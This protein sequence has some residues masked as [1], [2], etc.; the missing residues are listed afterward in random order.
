M[1]NYVSLNLFFIFYFLSESNL[2]SLDLWY[3]RKKNVS[4]R[5]VYFNISPYS[6]PSMLSQAQRGCPLK[7]SCPSSPPSCPPGISS[8]LDSCGCCRVCARQFNQ[9][10]SPNEPCDHIK[11]LRCHLVAAGD[12]DRGVCRGKRNKDSAVIV[13][14]LQLKN[15]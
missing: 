8:V 9:D 3:G 5:L 10:C 13:N 14:L 1:Q 4:Y 6:F 15:R 11:G 7:C 2:L 12:P